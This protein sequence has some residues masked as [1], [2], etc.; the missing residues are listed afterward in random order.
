MKKNNIKAPGSGHFGFFII[1]ACFVTIGALLLED[2][3]KLNLQTHWQILRFFLPFLLLTSLGIY[4]WERQK[5]ILQNIYHISKIDPLTKAY[6]RQYLYDRLA[7]IIHLGLQPVT[8]AFIDIDDFKNYNDFNDH[9]AG[10]WALKCIVDV[11]EPILQDDEFI[12]RYGGD[13]FVIVLMRNSAKTSD[14]IDKTL[15]YFKRCTS[16]SAS[17]G[18]AELKNGDNEESIIA[19]ADRAMYAAKT[20]R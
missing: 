12:A 6:N 13:E 5:N 3:L 18:I 1:W 9:R 2:A 11:F 15:N 17:A 20:K 8:I 14:L 4:L 16:L 7:E 10:D 19:R